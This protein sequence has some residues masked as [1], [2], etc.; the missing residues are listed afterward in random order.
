MP[1]PH[2][3]DSPGECPYC[4]GVTEPWCPGLLAF[5]SKDCREAYIAKVEVGGAEKCPDC[6]G[7]GYFHRLKGKASATEEKCERCK[8]HAWIFSA[9]G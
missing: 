1:R 7:K 4:G 8:G 6:G 2:V 9:E 5:C 3:S